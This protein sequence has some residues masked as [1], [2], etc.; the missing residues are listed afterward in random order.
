MTSLNDD[1][2]AGRPMFDLE[3]KVAVVTGAASGIGEATVRRLADAGA[4]PVL[5]DLVD[6][7]DEAER[8]GGIAAQADVSVEDDIAAA[9]A[10]A[11]DRFGRI[12]IA[13]NNAGI[14]LDPVP[15]SETTPEH[16]R[17]HADVNAL[18]VLWGLKHFTKSMPRGGAVVNT[19]SICGVTAFPE[20]GSYTSS[21]YSAVGLTQVGAMELGPRGI[22]VNCI[23]PTSVNTPMLWN[24]A[25]GEAEAAVLKAASPLSMIIEPE[26]AA[27]L[28]HFLAADDCPVISGQPILIDCGITAGISG[29]IWEAVQEAVE[30]EAG[31]GAED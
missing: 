25:E 20:Y 11:V 21:K 18:G 7:S 10:A 13:V 15:I 4:T 28:V 5:V 17:R 6:C 31:K 22:R 2:A 29:G 8:L 24:F 26:H 27:A 19:A 23:C 16:F 1:S 12:D 3:G 14:A 9:A 30:R